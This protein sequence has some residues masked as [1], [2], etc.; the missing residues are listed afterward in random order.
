MRGAFMD[1]KVKSTPDYKQSSLEE[2]LQFLETTANG[3]T[4]SE[5]NNRLRIFGYNE[6]A[7]KK[8]KFFF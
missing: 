4:E 1:S 3:L 5:V 7:G 6:I 2:T 8:K